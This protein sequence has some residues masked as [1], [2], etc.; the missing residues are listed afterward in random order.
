M[1][2]GTC[3][4]GGR[5][6]VF[7]AAG[8]RQTRKKP[9]NTR[10][11]RILRQAFRGCK[12]GL[13]L[14]LQHKELEN[15]R[16]AA[17]LPAEAA[18]ADL[19]Q[20]KGKEP[21]QFAKWFCTILR[22]KVRPFPCGS[23]GRTGWGR[24]GLRWLSQTPPTLTLPR[25]RRGGKRKAFSCYA[26]LVAGNDCFDGHSSVPS[27]AKRGKDRMGAR[28]HQWLQAISPLPD[29]CIQPIPT[30]KNGAAPDSPPASCVL[31]GRRVRSP[32]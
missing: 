27:P 32:W 20:C 28:P 1:D 19:L 25:C 5:P 15:P 16:F 7:C 4:V 30:R 9:R 17:Q 18:G 8:V 31:R 10:T 12:C 2:A 29:R 6:P 24:S 21:D 11:R 22:C 26:P 23:G 3:V 14:R 13:F